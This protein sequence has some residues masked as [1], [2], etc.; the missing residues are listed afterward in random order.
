[1]IPGVRRLANFVAAV[2]DRRADM[3][4]PPYALSYCS[5]ARRRDDARQLLRPAA[6]FADGLDRLRT[7]VHNAP[8]GQTFFSMGVQFAGASSVMTRFNF[9]VTIITMRRR[10]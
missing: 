1:V 7:A 9:L 10:A 2:D 3:A 4:S 5:F 6:R 8:I